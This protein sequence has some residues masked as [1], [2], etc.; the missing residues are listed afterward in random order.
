M[1]FLCIIMLKHPKYFYNSYELCYN[2]YKFTTEL[3]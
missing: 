3:K 1:F 2:K